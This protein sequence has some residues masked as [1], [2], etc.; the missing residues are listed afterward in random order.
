MAISPDAPQPAA[1]RPLRRDAQRNRDALLEAARAHFAEHGLHA[2]LE[3]IARQ[4][5]LAIGTLYRHFPTRLD[6]IQAVFTEKVR[7]WL[8]VAER[9]VAMEEAW[10]GFQLFAETMCALQAGDRGFADLAS[11][12]LP[13]S[14]S[15]E[16][17]QTRIHDLGVEIVHRAQE[18]GSLRADVTPED[19]AFVIWSHSRIAEATRGIAPV[20]W[21]RHLHLMLDAFRADRAHPLPEPPMTADQVYEAMVRLGGYDSCA[22]S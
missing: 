7:A 14:T 8:E 21:R 4:A 17:A 6:L 11:V 15:L 3:Q 5:Q 1:D 16:A 18:Q 22:G 9:A 10:Q 13:D 12:R 2:P 19:L 20:V